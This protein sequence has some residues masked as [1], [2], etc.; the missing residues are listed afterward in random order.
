MG[1]TQRRKQQILAGLADDALRARL[2]RFLLDET[3]GLDGHDTYSFKFRPF[4][5]DAQP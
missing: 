1:A 5:L 4:Q 3:N 2:R